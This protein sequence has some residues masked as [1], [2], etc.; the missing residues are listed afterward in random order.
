MSDPARTRLMAR[1]VGPFL[2]VLGASVALRMQTLPALLL[3]FVEDAPL[4]FVAGF[5]TLAIGLVMVAAHNWWNTPAAIVISILGWLTTVRGAVLLLAPDVVT[6]LAGNA[7][8][9]PSPAIGIGAGAVMALIGLWL[10]FVGWL[11]KPSA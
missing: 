1:I 10:A 3:A 7:M 2:L 4:L 9:S 6:T 11:S 5:V 8:Q